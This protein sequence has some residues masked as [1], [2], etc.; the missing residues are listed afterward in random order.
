MTDKIIDY[1]SYLEEDRRT[2]TFIADS[3]LREIKAIEDLIV[4]KVNQEMQV[5]KES[6]ARMH[7]LIEERF[8]SLKA[9]VCRESRIR[10]ES[11][12]QLKVCL[13]NDFP[14]LQDMIKQEQEQRQTSD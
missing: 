1:A 6:E 4:Q 13:Q 9:E 10:Y 5:R 8:N 2:Q 7:A 14:K 12:K 11:V 3:Q